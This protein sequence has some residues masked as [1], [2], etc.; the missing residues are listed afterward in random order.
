MSEL[1]SEQALEKRWNEATIKLDIIFTKVFGESEKLTL[2][3]LNIILPELKIK[4]IV[5]IVPEDR[6]KENIVYRGVRFDVYARDERN[7]MYDIEM[8]V[9]NHHD[10]GKRIAYYQN[11]L[12]AKA[13]NSGQKFFKKRDTYVIFVCD[14]DYFNLGLPIYHTTTRLEED[15]NKVVDTG[16]Y[17]VILNS[18][19]TDF[20]SVSPEVKAFLEYVKENKVSNEF[21]EDVEKEV[22][23]VKSSTE[24]RD[25]FMDW[26]EKL[27][28]VAYYAGK[29]ERKENI[30][31]SIKKLDSQ[32]YNKKQIIDSITAVTAFTAE[33]ISQ[34]YDELMVK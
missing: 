15:L 26:E 31:D 13:L 30:I 27:E 16:E 11:K 17:N 18:R 28:E 1:L 21:T 4:E 8:Q 12:T 5:D 14:F 24:T 10:L 23:K 20:S 25:I 19:A 33:E 34:C 2:E 29:K 22:R 3:L 7:R 32:G 6:E 9:V